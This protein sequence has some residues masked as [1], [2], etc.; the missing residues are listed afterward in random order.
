MKAT[1]DEMLHYTRDH[2]TKLARENRFPENNKIDHDRGRCLV[3]HPEEIKGNVQLFLL[4]LV[5]ECIL[6][7]R[8]EFDENLLQAIKEELEAIK[9]DTEIDLESL[10]QARPDAF[11][12]WRLWALNAINTAFEMLSIHGNSVPYL[13]IE[14]NFSPEE[15]DLRL[16]Y[17]FDKQRSN[18]IRSN[19]KSY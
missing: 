10:L 18:A 14:D 12:A 5:V 4:D 16:Q 11:K 19:K 8:P 1:Y 2:F 6:E 9:S 17:L 3:C 13:Q 7:R 15:R